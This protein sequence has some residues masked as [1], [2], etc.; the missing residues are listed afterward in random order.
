MGLRARF[1][2][3]TYNRFVRGSERAG[4]EDLRAQ[5]VPRATGRVLEIGAG[6]GLNL[7]HYGPS[8]E[9]T[10]TEPDPSMLR[11]LSRAAE[12]IRPGTT[13]LR[14][15]AE[16]LP[17]EDAVFDTVVCTLVLCGVD[18]QPQAVREIKR[19]LR[20]GGQLLFLEHVR[21]HDEHQARRQD[22]FNV[23]NRA[24]VL[25]ECNRPTRRTLDGSGLLVDE[26]TET[27]FPKAPTWLSPLVYGHATRPAG[28]GSAESAKAEARG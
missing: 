4:M 8:V 11:R 17:F 2:A 23:L 19:V 26:I 14:A 16:Q 27:E 28:L 18:D 25:C 13:V 20:P 22:R 21:S 24:L 1:F 6:T 9:L 10:V 3:A 7:P 5:L 12:R 15:P